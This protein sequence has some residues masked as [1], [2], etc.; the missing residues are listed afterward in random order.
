[1]VF[2]GY[3]YLIE[4]SGEFGQVKAGMD[5]WAGLVWLVAMATL[6]S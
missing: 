3:I 2:G 5:G 4:S 6:Q 1:M